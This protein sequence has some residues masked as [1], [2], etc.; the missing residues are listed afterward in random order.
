MLRWIGDCLNSSIGKKAVMAVTGLA[1]VGYLFVH[2]WGNLQL[3]AG[4]TVFDRYVEQIQEWGVLLYVAEAGLALL[5]IGHIYLGVRLAMENREARSQGYVVRSTRGKATVSS[6]T[7]LV[8]G[9]VVMA[10]LI[11]HVLDFRFG[12]GFLDAPA[13]TTRELLTTPIHA[14]IYLVGV[15]ALTFHLAHAFQS[16]FQSLGVNHPRVTPILLKLGLAIALLL[17]FG[18]ASFPIYYMFAGGAQ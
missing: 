6:M 4:D 18:F 12:A 17:G 9:L 14:I 3:Y 16:S 7:M 1:L 15:V 10:F 11:K 8:T 13:V 5:F 2:L